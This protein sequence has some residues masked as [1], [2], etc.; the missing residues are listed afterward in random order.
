LVSVREDLRKPAPS[1]RP[2]ESLVYLFQVVLSFTALKKVQQN[3]DPQNS[4]P[5]HAFPHF[6]A[7][8]SAKNQ[9]RLQPA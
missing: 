9:S 8:K 1:G 3:N 7:A 4:I 6:A 2:F 5:V